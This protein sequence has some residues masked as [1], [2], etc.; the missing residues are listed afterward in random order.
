MKQVV[1]FLK[2]KNE[3]EVEKL[4]AKFRKLDGCYEEGNRDGVESGEI[5]F[6]KFPEG[7]FEMFADFRQRVIIIA[8]DWDLE[9]LP[10][11]QAFIKEIKEDV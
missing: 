7:A 10:K 5:C 11:F 9:K 4:K 3:E 2:L 6:F 8:S 1:A